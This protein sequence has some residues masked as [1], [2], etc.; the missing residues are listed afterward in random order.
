MLQALARTFCSITH[1]V[2]KIRLNLISEKTSCQP[3]VLSTTTQL[4]YGPDEEKSHEI[5]HK[6]VTECYTYQNHISSNIINWCTYIST[7]LKQDCLNMTNKR[8]RLTCHRLSRQY[9]I[10]S[11]MSVNAFY[12]MKNGSFPCLKIS[13]TYAKWYPSFI[14][15]TKIQ[16]F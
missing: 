12:F 6:T 16:V 7:F 13:S 5:E 4:A 11:G 9:T 14:Q 8:K 15:I 3:W 1:R 10:E 2:V